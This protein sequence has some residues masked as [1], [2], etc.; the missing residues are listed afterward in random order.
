M[1]TEIAAYLRYVFLRAFPMTSAV[2]GHRSDRRV[3][4]VRTHTREN[5]ALFPSN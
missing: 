5:E 1:S 2:D 4:S 3:A